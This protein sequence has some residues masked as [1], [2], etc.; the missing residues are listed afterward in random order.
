MPL[1]ETP[2]CGKSGVG[3]TATPPARLPDE[4][5]RSCVSARGGPSL[6]TPY[7][8]PGGHSKAHEATLTK[9]QEASCRCKEP[10]P[11]E[12][13]CALLGPSETDHWV[14]RI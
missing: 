6:G 11:H 7:A 13:R 5:R 14:G 10:T 1:C 9:Q 8:F 3:T 2:P 12:Q 4:F